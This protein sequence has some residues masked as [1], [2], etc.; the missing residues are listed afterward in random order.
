V[1]VSLVCTAGA[2]V[3][4]KGHLSAVIVGVEMEYTHTGWKLNIHIYS[5]HVC[6]CV[7][8]ICVYSESFVEWRLNIPIQ[9]GNRTYT[10]ILC[11]CVCTVYMCIF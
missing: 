5:M 4:I 7:P 3:S 9:G 2:G 10:Y 6:V 8:S 1:G 11:M